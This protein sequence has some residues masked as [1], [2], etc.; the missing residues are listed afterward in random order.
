M[1]RQWEV[2]GSSHV[3]VPFEIEYGKVRNLREGLSLE[4]VQPRDQ[5]CDLPTYS[6]VPFQD[7]MNAAFE[8][9]VVWIRDDIAPPTAEPLQL[10][11]MMPEVEFARDEYGNVLGGIRLA[12]H[13]VATAK[14]TGMNNGSNRFCFLYGSHQPFDQATLDRLYPNHNAYVDA[15]REVAQQ[16]VADG[17]ILPIAAQQTI[18]EAQD[19]DIGR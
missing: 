17:Y 15:V 9:L 1:F 11:R 6:R 19:S 14:N 12:E 16:N 18:R 4:N 10:R 8:H 2:A 13:V 3:D 5:D 7:V